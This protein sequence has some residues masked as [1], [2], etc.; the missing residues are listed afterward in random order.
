MSFD[1]LNNINY[2]SKTD[3]KNKINEYLDR[4]YQEGNLTESKY[5]G[6]KGEE[7]K[8]IQGDSRR[9]APEKIGSTKQPGQPRQE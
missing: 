6:F 7:R 4:Q 3:L 8:T 2:I 5:K 1:N 9:N